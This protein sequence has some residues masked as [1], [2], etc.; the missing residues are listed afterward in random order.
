MELV[1][2][3]HLARCAIGIGD[4]DQPLLSLSNLLSLNVAQVHAGD[5]VASH[6]ELGVDGEVNVIELQPPF[7]AAVVLERLLAPHLGIKQQHQVVFGGELGVEIEP[8]AVSV[9][10][11]GVVGLRRRL[12][13][14]RDQLNADLPGFGAVCRLILRYLLAK[15]LHQLRRL[16]LA[17]DAHVGIL[18]KAVVEQHPVV[19]QQPFVEPHPARLHGAGAAVLR[20]CAIRQCHPAHRG[21]AGR[22]ELSS[23]HRTPENRSLAQLLWLQMVPPSHDSRTSVSALPSSLLNE[24][25]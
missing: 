21:C 14:R 20:R 6:L 4:A 19:R 9:R 3:Q 24:D 11:I 17:E 15:E 18:R 1:N 13:H 25:L 10:Q 22:E 23:W 7:Q 12:R 5:L 8:V 2:H 16:V